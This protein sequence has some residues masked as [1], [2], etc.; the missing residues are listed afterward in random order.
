M[1]W[2]GWAFMVLILTQEVGNAK[3]GSCFIYCIVQTNTTETDR[4]RQIHIQ[5]DTHAQI[6][7]GVYQGLWMSTMTQGVTERLM[8]AR[9]SA[10]HCH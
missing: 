9:S 6:C 4:M 2:V 5:T 7:R 3:D 1:G 10:S 8:P